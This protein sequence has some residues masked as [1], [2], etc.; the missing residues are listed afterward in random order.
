[1]NLD[2]CRKDWSKSRN[3]RKIGYVKFDLHYYRLKKIYTVK[4]R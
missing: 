2:E 4:G 1:M 3:L